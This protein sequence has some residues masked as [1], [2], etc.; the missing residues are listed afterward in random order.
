MLS[1]SQVEICS[2]IVCQYNYYVVYYRY[3]YTDYTVGMERDYLIE[4]YCSDQKPIYENGVYSFT[5]CCYYRITENKYISHALQEQG[6][7]SPISADDVVY[8]NAVEGAPQF[9]YELSTLKNHDFERDALYIAVIL[10]AAAV[11]LR[12]LF[13][14]GK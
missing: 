13:G 4:L 2:D 11:L 10:L 14:G 8:T 9:C 12:L 7:F 1:T 3:D 6:S 5:D